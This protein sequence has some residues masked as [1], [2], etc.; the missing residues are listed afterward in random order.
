MYE[1]YFLSRFLDVNFLRDGTH[2][3]QNSIIVLHLMAIES[4]PHFTKERYLLR[5][6]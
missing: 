5:F 1:T 6:Y 3:R 4:F 2:E